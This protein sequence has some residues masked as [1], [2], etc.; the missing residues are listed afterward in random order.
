MKD[1]TIICK[2]AAL[3]LSATVLLVGCGSAEA[4]PAEASPRSLALLVNLIHEDSGR[5]IAAIAGDVPII[6]LNRA[7]T[8]RSILRE[9]A[10]FVG[11]DEALC[12][13]LQGQA[14][15]AYFREHWIGTDIRYLLFQGVPDLENTVERSNGA[16]QGLT[17][18]GF[19]PVA[20]AE[21]QVCDFYR[22][23]AQA[24]METLL[25]TGTAYDCILCNN[26]AMALG[27][28]DALKAAGKAPSEVPIVSVDCTEEGN[29]ALRSGDLYMTV[30]QDAAIQAETAVTAAINLLSGQ[31]FDTGISVPLEVDGQPTAYSIYIPASAVMAD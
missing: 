26:N 5:Q 14:L 18:A 21:F 10:V 2:L 27:V 25:E 22:N 1:H 7:P 8:D 6:F 31:P 13:A 17:D 30:D 28:I 15:A 20:A 12:G 29:E 24:A 19:T 3:V 9:T 11:M 4:A 16:L 23:R